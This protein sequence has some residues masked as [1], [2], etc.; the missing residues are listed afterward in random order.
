MTWETYLIYLAALAAFFATPPDTSQLLIMSNSIQHGVKRTSWTICGDLTANILQM[1]AA[2][3]GLAALIATS[4]HA[5]T[6]IKWL[7]VAYLAWIGVQLFFSKPREIEIKGQKR[8]PALKLFQQG[9]ITSSANPY[10][11]IFFAALFPQFIDPELATLPQV[12]ILGGTY[13]LVDGVILLIWGTLA[14]Y[15]AERLRAVS[16]GLVNRFCGFVLIGAAMLLA[17]KD[18]E[19]GRQK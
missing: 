10:A 2:A 15:S 19:P 11:V 6:L 5:F 9:F 8:K 3:F 1:T 7:G 18:F 13:I 16:S 14:I 12:A 4:A 17:S